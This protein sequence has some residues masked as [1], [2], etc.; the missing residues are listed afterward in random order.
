MKKILCLLSLMILS[1]ASCSTVYVDITIK[2]KDARFM[3]WVGDIID[4]DEIK[5]NLLLEISTNHYQYLD[6][7]YTFDI[8]S[9]GSKNMPEHS[10]Y[11]DLKQYNEEQKIVYLINITDPK[12]TLYGLNM[13]S[14]K[15]EI[16]HILTSS[17]FR[18][19]TFSSRAPA[20]RK[21]QYEIAIYPSY[22]SVRYFI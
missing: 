5:Q 9:D 13:N 4:N 15:D 7:N 14:S 21:D 8:A 16:D 19:S 3:Y 11:Y 18:Y 6:S 2:P 1:L 17:G 22:M 20:Y 12:I 10:V